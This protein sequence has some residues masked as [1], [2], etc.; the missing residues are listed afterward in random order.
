ME[1]QNLKKFASNKIRFPL[2]FEK[3]DLF[4]KIRELFCFCFTMYT[5]RK[6]FTIEIENRREAP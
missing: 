2:N 4:Y 6:K 5:M 1:D 3:R